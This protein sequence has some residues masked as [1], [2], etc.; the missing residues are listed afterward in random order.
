MIDCGEKKEFHSAP[1][2]DIDQKIDVG[3]IVDSDKRDANPIHTGECPV[4]N[5]EFVVT[6]PRDAVKGRILRTAPCE[7]LQRTSPGGGDCMYGGKTECNA[8]KC[9]RNLLE[10]FIEND[11]VLTQVPAQD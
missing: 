3:E 5:N 7:H 10:G 8:P 4:D 1:M 11:P 2:M 6:S 9:S